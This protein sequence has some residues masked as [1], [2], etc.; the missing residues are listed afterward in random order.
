MGRPLGSKNR[1]SSLQ[2]FARY[3]EVDQE[4]GCW[5]WLKYVDPSTGYGNFRQ[6][7]H[8]LAHRWA[9][10]TFRGEIPKGMWVLHSCDNRRCVNPDHL[11]LGNSRDNVLDMVAKGRQWLQD[12]ERRKDAN[13]WFRPGHP[14]MMVEIS[15]EAR[16]R[17]GESNKGQKRSAEQRERMSAAQ[18]KRQQWAR[19]GTIEPVRWTAEQRLAHSRRVTEWWARRKATTA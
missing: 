12:P 10:A 9:Y 14:P 17:A 8:Q 18:R 2:K 16:K 11:F 5:N 3:H 6:D 19:D 7:G 15:P 13:P 1:I 4:T